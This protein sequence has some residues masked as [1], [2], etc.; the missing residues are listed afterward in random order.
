[1]KIFKKINKNI[2]NY[3]ILTDDIEDINVNMNN[4]NYN[5][6][7]DKNINKIINDYNKYEMLTNCDNINMNMNT[8][9]N[10]LIKNIK[11]TN[12]Q[13]NNK[14]YN[15]D[16]ILWNND[17]YFKNI[18]DD[19][20]DLEKSENIK[21]IYL[22]KNINPCKF[23]SEYNKYSYKNKSFNYIVTKYDIIN[24]SKMNLI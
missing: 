16:L 2:N 22:M 9:D 1:M 23:K 19:Y 13:I 10:E 14:N 21:Y 12:K 20:K 11:L 6:N 24:K 5:K 15:C 17:I 3:E 7:K 4:Y 8:N 18:V